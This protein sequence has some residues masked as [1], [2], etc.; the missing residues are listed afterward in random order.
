M[1]NT[2]IENEVYENCKPCACDFIESII[3]IIVI[4]RDREPV[5][6]IKPEREETCVHIFVEEPFNKIAKAYS[7]RSSMPKQKSS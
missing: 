3:D 5:L 6:K 7:K 1:I 2:L 4:A